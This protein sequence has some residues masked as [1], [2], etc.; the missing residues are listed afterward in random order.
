MVARLADIVLAEADA[1]K[2]QAYAHAMMA[3]LGM[4]ARPLDFLSSER[5]K[6]NVY[7]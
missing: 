5:T 6:L 3:I 1:I 4:L 7:C 2:K